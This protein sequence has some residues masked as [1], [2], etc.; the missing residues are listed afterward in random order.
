MREVEDHTLANPDLVL[1]SADIVKIQC[2]T[3]FSLCE[4]LDSAGLVLGRDIAARLNFHTKGAEGSS[5]AEVVAAL[6]EK[7]GSLEKKDDELL[8]FAQSKIRLISND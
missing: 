6:A 5:W 2:A 8:K 1:S 4:S 3:F 7:L